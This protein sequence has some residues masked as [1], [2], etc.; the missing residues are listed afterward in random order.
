MSGQQSKDERKPGGS[1]INEG[2]KGG[3]QNLSISVRGGGRDLAFF[4]GPSLLIPTN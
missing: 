3:S 1:G 4:N 2:V